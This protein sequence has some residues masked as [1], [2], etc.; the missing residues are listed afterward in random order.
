MANILLARRDQTMRNYLAD[1]LRRYG[2]RVTITDCHDGMIAAM[3]DNQEFAMLVADFGMD[4]QDGF[5]LVRD[6]QKSVPHMRIVFLSGFSAIGIARSANQH[7]N[8]RIVT[9]PFHIRELPEQVN[10]ILSA[11]EEAA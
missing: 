2:H 6:F 9:R 3:N 5:E 10:V 7:F 8:A 1:Q 4:G 11:G